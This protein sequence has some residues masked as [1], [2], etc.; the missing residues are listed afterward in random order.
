MITAFLSQFIAP[1]ALAF[2]Q[3]LM[4]EWIVISA[5]MY[6]TTQGDDCLEIAT[7][8]RLGRLISR[9]TGGLWRTMP[10]P[11]SVPQRSGEKGLARQLEQEIRALGN[12]DG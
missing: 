3:F 12:L 1:L 9:K 6:A 7:R 5:Y 8:I 4:L 11:S 2:A 10:N